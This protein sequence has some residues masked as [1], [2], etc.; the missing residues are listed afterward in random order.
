MSAFGWNRARSPEILIKKI[1]GWSYTC[2]DRNAKACAQVPLRLYRVK[3]SARKNS[4]IKAIDVDFTKQKYLRHKLAERISSSDQVEEI[5]QHPMLDLLRRV[6]PSQNAFDLKDITVRYLEAIGVSYWFLERNGKEVI[7]IWP[8]MAQYVKIFPDK[9][10]GIKHYSYGRGQKK[11]IIQPED[12]IHFRYTSLTDP[13]IG[14]SPLAA[15]EQSVDLNDSMNKF[16]IASFRNGGRPSVVLQVPTDGFIDP[17]EKKRIE[18]DFR[19]NQG[20]V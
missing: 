6:N 4:K 14:D 18:S 16:E 11:T 7:N 10:H 3:G 19:M 15:G 2:I 20:G 1:K 9:K 13:F 5:T 8:L 12:M 17:K